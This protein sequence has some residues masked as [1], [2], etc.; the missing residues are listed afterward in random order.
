LI[1]LTRAAGGA[2]T[3][4][5]A[6]RVPRASKVQRADDKRRR[7]RVKSLRRGGFDD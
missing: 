6:T 1:E 2:P 5:R 3:P 7:S 4:R